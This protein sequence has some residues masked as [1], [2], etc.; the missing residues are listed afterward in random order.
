MAP[1]E[2]DIG[3]IL[4]RRFGLCHARAGGYVVNEH[5]EK[6]EQSESSEHGLE[7]PLPHRVAP[8]DLRIFRQ[9]AVALGI[10]GVVEH[11]DDMGA[12][13]GLGIVDAGVLPAEI[14]LQLL[15]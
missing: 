13:D 15:S 6:T 8:R 9:V 14:F 7:E 2:V 1:L 10:G 12:A 5:A 3:A 4:F 11:V